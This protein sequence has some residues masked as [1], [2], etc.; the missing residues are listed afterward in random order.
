MAKEIFS[1]KHIEIEGIYA[2]ESWITTNEKLLL[3]Y[4]DKIFN[5][6]I[7]ELGQI[8][9][10]NTPNQVFV[11]LKQPSNTPNYNQVKQNLSLY[12]DGI[13]DP[14][15]MGTILRIAD[16]FG[17]PQV[18]CSPDCV[19]VYNPK[20]IQSTMGAFLRVDT[21]VTTLSALRKALPDLVLYG[22]TMTGENI[23]EKRV[24]ATGVIVIGNE[25]QG[26]S[27]ENLSLVDQQIRIPQVDGSG[28]ES[29]NAGVATGIICAVFRNV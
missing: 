22:A 12:L 8:S 17:I 2:L 29:L 26:I 16:W 28:M 20:V 18:F 24:S 5:I 10:L 1:Q 15:N 3:A 19:E 13:Q 27:P 14:G 23:F 9:S 4:R 11:V 6:S 21:P 25:G 7:T